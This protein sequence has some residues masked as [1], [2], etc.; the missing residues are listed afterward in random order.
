[1]YGRVLFPEPAA[2]EAVILESDIESQE[3]RMSKRKPCQ[4]T[5]FISVTERECGCHQD[6][7]LTRHIFV[8]CGYF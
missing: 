7:K 3:Y 2:G 6:S 5:D 8:S 1:M 4:L